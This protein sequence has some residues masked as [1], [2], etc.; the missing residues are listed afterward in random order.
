VADMVNM[1][2]GA[3]WRS[4]RQRRAADARRVFDRSGHSWP[5]QWEPAAVA[6]HARARNVRLTRRW[7]WG[8]CAAAGVKREDKVEWRA[9]VDC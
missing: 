7:R 8:A 1:G 4:R 6:S 5:G 3:D 2:G 9:S